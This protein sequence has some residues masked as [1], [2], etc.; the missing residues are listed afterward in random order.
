MEWS[1]LPEQSWRELVLAALGHPWGKAPA[2]RVE[3]PGEWHAVIFDPAAILPIDRKQQA[4]LATREPSKKRGIKWF[5]PD[6]VV[7]VLS[8]QHR[9]RLEAA[10]GTGDVLG[11]EAGPLAEDLTQFLEAEL[12]ADLYSRLESISSDPEKRIPL[13]RV[14][15]DLPTDHGTDFCARLA[16]LEPTFARDIE[17]RHVLLVG[18][19]GQGKT[20][21]GQYLCQIH[22]AYLLAPRISMLG[23]DAEGQLGPLLR[24]VEALRPAQL[25]FP[26]RVPLH[27]FAAQLSD[28]P[29]PLW[30]WILARFRLQ[31]GRDVDAKALL[32]FFDRF[33]ILV[34]LDGLD[35]VPASANRDAVVSAIQTFIYYQ[36]GADFHRGADILAVASTRPQGYRGEFEWQPTTLLPLETNHARTYAERLIRERNRTDKERQ[37]IVRERFERALVDTRTAALSRSPLQVTILCALLERQSAAPPQRWALFRDYFRVIYDRERD[38]DIPSTRVLGQHEQVVRRLHWEVGYLLHVRSEVANGEDAS[39][40]RAEFAGVVTRI[41]DHRGFSGADAEALR[42]Q[43]VEAALLRLVFLV[44]VGDEHV[45]FEIRSLQEFAA[46]ERLVEAEGPIV[47]ERLATIARPA[48]WRNVFAFAAGHGEAEHEPLVAAIL[49]V[50]ERF[51]DEAPALAAEMI[52]EGVGASMP[53]RRAFLLDTAA[54]GLAGPLA[55]RIVEVLAKQAPERVSGAPRLSVRGW[56]AADAAGVEIRLEQVDPE[57]VPEAL[58]TT[59]EREEDIEGAFWRYPPERWQDH[60]GD[61][62]TPAKV[63]YAFYGHVR[64]EFEALPGHTLDWVP[65]DTAFERPNIPATAHPGW[66][67]ADAAW[68]FRS[69]PTPSTLAALLEAAPKARPASLALVNTLPWPVGSILA[70]PRPEQ[71]AEDAREGVFGDIDDW[72]CAEDRWT[73]ASPDAWDRTPA[74]DDRPYDATICT[75]G[76]PP[77]VQVGLNT[78][79]AMPTELTT[80]WRQSDGTDFR[81]NFWLSF[82]PDLFP[83]AGDHRWSG[84]TTTR[85]VKLLIL[86]ARKDGWLGAWRDLLGLAGRARRR[87]EPVPEMGSLLAKPPP[88]DPGLLAFAAATIRAGTR[89]LVSADTLASIIPPDDRL[90]ADHLLVRLTQPEPDP[91]AEAEL[92]RLL[93]L[94]DTLAGDLVDASRAVPEPHYDDTLRL[95]ISL[96]SLPI[97][98]RLLDELADRVAAHPSG[99]ADPTRAIALQLPTLP[100]TS[101][102]EPAPTFTA[103]RLQ[104]VKLV[105]FKGHAELEITNPDRGQWTLFLGD[106]GVGKTSILR[107]IALALLP[108]EVAQ[109]WVTIAPAPTVR[110]GAST[111]GA[112]IQLSGQTW[113]CAISGSSVQA[114]DRPTDL[115]LVGYGPHRG[116]VHGG[117]TEPDFSPRAAVNTLF[118]DGASLTHP[119]R[120]LQTWSLRAY[121]RKNGDQQ[122]FEAL[123]ATLA[124]LLPG[125]DRIDVSSEG[126]RV[127][128]PNFPGVPLSALSDGYLT[129]AGWMLD[130]VAR[131][132]EWA[133]ARKLV[134]DGDFAQRMTGLVL[135]DE[136]DLHLHPQWQRELVVT[137]RSH[138]PNLSFVA[139]THNPITLLGAEPGEICVLQRTSAG[140]TATFRDIPRGADADH[141][142]TGDWF[143]L[144]STV[145]ADTLR[146]LDEQRALLR[147]DPEA[148]RVAEIRETLRA[149]L[150]G[151]STSIERLVESVAAEILTE[152]T[153]SLTPETLQVARAKIAERVRQRRSGG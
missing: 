47:E 133:R 116:S 140:V 98:T 52:A 22:R 131:W 39:L 89:I 76:L 30:D 20:T 104:R 8:A 67:V 6:D 87:R 69:N 112:A 7:A 58:I 141:V 33:P 124:K 91:T 12:L 134:V 80:L 110:I 106:N 125:V 24:Q 1:R 144:I 3:L 93:P 13:S 45:G 150:G 55:P 105:D 114:S 29:D 119:D 15:V 115:F 43:L 16:S 139:T 10:C 117:S 50:L 78:N 53:A 137:L 143:G 147:T 5:G 2:D 121:E 129:T 79:S 123:K 63:V 138:F 127:H 83:A 113:T 18:G 11:R 97:R 84:V 36:R 35:E 60:D 145:D 70:R 75:T 108:I 31:I 152:E 4:L 122:F 90:A 32:A 74:D 23:P 130:L 37:A 65:L 153:A 56:A 46:A 77:A 103:E 71:F 72:R 51:P 59:P 9:A 101:L 102:P 49:R 17:E 42:T 28:G 88:Y 149:R 19:P 100:G 146:L 151:Q 86:A 68:R 142:L 21:V 61:F 135:I 118:D 54:R 34:V 92:R 95:A 62:V 111:A 26:I 82:Y 107:A 66:Q 48:H 40:S 38:R 126:S 25:R 27:R 109:T 94:V 57:E 14:F 99:L 132:A 81:V 136:I 85:S 128:G 44:G 96:T 64:L 120:W 41:L 148:A 73:L